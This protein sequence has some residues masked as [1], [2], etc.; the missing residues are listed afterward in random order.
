MSARIPTSSPLEAKTKRKRKKINT[1]NTTILMWSLVFFIAMGAITVNVFTLTVQGIH[2]H[3]NTDI[4]AIARQVHIRETTLQANRGQILDRNGHVIAEDVAT[5]RIIA[6]LSPNRLGI[7]NQP[8]FVVDPQATAAALAPILNTSEATLLQLLQRN[9]FQTELGTA[10]RNLTLSQRQ[11]IEALHLPGIAFERTQSRNYPAGIFASHLIG[12]AQYD[13]NLAMVN[14][15]AGLEQAL[16]P[17]L[18]GINGLVRFQSDAAGFVF[19]DMLFEETLPIH[20]ANVVTTLDREIQEA[21]ELS[22]NQTMSDH[23]ASMAFAMVMN[24]QTAEIIAYGHRPTFD[25]NRINISNFMDINAQ[26]LIEPGSV[27]KTLLWAS[28]IE[29]GVYDPNYLMPSRIFHMGIQNGLPTRLP[30]A[31]GSFAFIRNFN[32]VD[33]GL[34]NFDR[35]FD[36]SLNTSV[37]ILLTQFL[38]PAAF[39]STLDALSMFNN[40]NVFGLRSTN[41]RRVARFPIEMLTLGFGQGSTVVPL[42]MLSAYQALL[43]NGQH[44]RPSVVRHIVEPQSGQIVYQLEPQLLN[45]VFSSSTTQAMISLLRSAVVNGTGRHYQ[46]EEANIIGKTGTSQIP[47]EDGKYRSDKF[48]Y[49]FVAALPYENPQFLVYYAFSAENTTGAHRRV[50]PQ[51]ALMRKIAVSM[52]LTQDQSS[53]ETKVIHVPSFVNQSVERFT[54]FA[55]TNNLRFLVIGEGRNIS[56]LSIAPNSS[57]LSNALVFV[58]TNAPVVKM[59]DVIG[60]SVS[61]VHHL[62]RFTGLDIEIVGEGF[63]VSSN[64]A[65]HEPI[66]QK[67]ILQA[68]RP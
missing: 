48:L 66:D 47:G 33:H 45:K 53:T 25:A 3:S 38:T 18:R 65:I 8:A 26:S 36:I 35:S 43:N 51:R 57:V 52:N 37:G 5:Y 44:I 27:M 64:I 63:I 61:E 31:S 55:L 56:H 67:I 4:A 12:F 41:G 58:Q 21:L 60:L 32:Q 54:T 6:F 9:V 2:R 49:S 11:A 68:Q 10:G 24:I 15:R 19:K 39:I 40:L 7:N 13:H 34:V 1:S 59:P 50:E 62:A 14:G 20:G 17:F 22:L 46:I 29:H 28:A 23:N 42:N 16:N 30:N